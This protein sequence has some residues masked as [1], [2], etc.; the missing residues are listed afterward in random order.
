MGARRWFLHSRR[1]RI[2]A[3]TVTIFVGLGQQAAQAADQVWQQRENEI[4]AAAPTTPGQQSGSAAG[5][6]HRASTSDTRAITDAQG[7]APALAPHQLPME[8]SHLRDSA[9]HLS[10][11]TAS[12]TGTTTSPPSSPAV[13][14]FDPV[15]SVPQPA[16]GDEH[17]EVYHNPDNTDTARISQDRVQF[18]RPDHSWTP[19]D[20][21]LKPTGSGR[22]TK[23]ADSQQIE[24]AG[25]A[26]DPTLSSIAP[27]AA[28][29]VSFGL[30]DAAPAKAQIAG[31]TA[32]YPNVSAG[33]DLQEQATGSGLKENL[34]LHSAAAPVNWVFPFTAKGLSAST[35]P[36][37][38]VVFTDASGAVQVRI[39][40][41][42][43]TD[44]AIDPRSN[45]GASSNGVTYQLVTY[46][47]GPALQVKLDAGW[48]HDPARRFPVMVDP[49]SLTTTAST[50]VGWVNGDS[51]HA[52]SPLLDVGS[53]DNG[54][55]SAEADLRF[56]NFASTFGNDFIRGT[57]LSVYDAWDTSCTPEQVAVTPITVPWDVNTINS[58]QG[59]LQ[60]GLPIGAKSFATSP[61]CLGSAGSAN[62]TTI[63]LNPSTFD[64]WAH[65]AP[66]YGLKLS[67]ETNSDTTWKQLASDHSANA[68]YLSVDFSPYGVNWTGSPT[69]STIPTATTNGVLQV[70][71]QNWGNTAWTPSNGYVLHYSQT[72]SVTGAALASGT[73]PMP[74]TVA[75]QQSTT[76]PIT[77]AKQPAGSPL[78]VTLD[79]WAPGNVAFSS[80]L[81]PTESFTYIGVDMAPQVDGQSPPSNVT[82]GT[83]TP[84]LTASGHDPD[85]YPNPLEFGF[86]V[87]PAAA[88]WPTGC[89]S[90]GWLAAGVTA[91]TVSAGTLAYN[92]SYYWVTEDYD[93]L[94]PSYQSAPSWFTTVVGQPV[95]TSHL[96]QNTDQHGY[97]PEVGNYTTATTDLTVPGAGL[98]LSVQRTYNSLDPRT[99]GAFGAGWWSVL[100]MQAAPDADGTGNVVITY[101]NGQTVRFGLN[102]DGTFTPPQG[103]YATLTPTGTTGYTLVDKDGTTYVFTGTPGAP[104][105]AIASITDRAGH[106]ELFSYTGGHLATVTNT[107]S[108]RTLHI[109]WLT[110]PG[111][112]SAH[113]TSI[114]TDPVTGTDPTTAITATYQYTA[115]ELTGACLPSLQSACTGYGYQAGA[116]DRTAVLDAAPASFW[117]LAEPAGAATATSEVLENEGIDAATSLSATFGA[118]GPNPTATAAAFDGTASF[119]QLPKG[120]VEGTTF[121]SLQLWF[122]TSASGTAQMLFSTDHDAAN[123]ANPGSGAM[124]VLYVGTDNKLHGHF[125]DNTV[126][127]MASANPVNDGKWHQVTIT[128]SAGTQSLYLDGTPIA[129]ET[130]Q[131]LNIDPFDIVGAGVFNAKGWPA[132]PGGNT[133]S[134]FHGSIADV[135]FYPQPLSAIQ[136]SSQYHS[137]VTP[138]A[139]LTKITLPSG[140]PAAGMTYDTHADRVTQ[141]T[142]QNGGA[143]KVGGPTVSGTSAIYRSA[144]LGAAP[145][146]YWRLGDAAGST[147]SSETGSQTGTYTNTTLGATGPFG[148]N[149]SAAATFNGT[150]SSVQLPSSTGPALGGTNPVI[151]DYGP[152]AV[153]L[154]FSTTSSG[155]LFSFSKDPITAAKST[156][157]YDFTP[158]LYVGTDGK[159]YGEFN[160]TSTADDETPMHSSVVVNDGK[161]HHVALSTNGDTQTL[162]LDGMAT[163]SGASWTATSDS[164]YTYVGAGF[165]GNKW[166]ATPQRSGTDNLGSPDYFSGSIAEVALYRH[167]L[168]AADVVHHVKAYGN[169]LSHASPTERIEVQDPSGNPLDYTYD[170][171]N[172]GRLVTAGDAL[173]NVTSYG[174]DTAGFLNTITDPNGVPIITGHDIRGNLISRTTCQSFLAANCATSYYTYFPDDSS[175]TLS[176]DPR[177]DLLTSYRDGR[178]VDS[179]DPT[180]AIR[181][182]YDTNGNLLS[183]VGPSVAGAPSGQMTTTVYT[184]GSATYPSLDGATAPPGLPAHT[185]S[186]SGTTTNYR[187]FANGDIAQV[188]DP[189]GLVT[190][191]THDNLGRLLTAKQTSDSYPAGLV[192]SY[193]YDA[194]GRQSSLTSPGVTD[195][196][197]GTV[198]TAKTTTAYDPDG[199]ITTQTVA[200]T[201][202]SDPARI[203]TTGYDISDRVTSIKEPTGVTTHYGYNLFGNNTSAIDASGT[204]TDYSYD[205]DGRRTT[206]TL[207]GYIGDPVNPSTP[208]DLVTESRA[209]DPAGRLASVTDSMGR[210]TQYKYFDDGSVSAVFQPD[211]A[212]TTGTGYRDAI[213][214]YDLAGN[215]TSKCVDNCTYNPLTALPQNQPLLFQGQYSQYQ[216]DAGDRVTSTQTQYGS[217][218][219][220]NTSLH[221]PLI[222]STNVSYTPDDLPMSVSTSD[223]ASP[224]AGNE[225]TDYTYDPLGRLTSSTAH[226]PLAAQ[227]SA[228][229]LLGQWNLDDGKTLTAHDGSAGAT[230]APSTP[231]AFDGT[232]YTT[233]ST[234]IWNGQVARLVYQT[235]G[236]LVVYRNSDNT[237]LWSSQTGG[238]TSAV[239]VFQTDG[240]L[241]IYSDATFKTAL[242]NSGTSVAGAQGTFNS[243]GD[244]TINSPS[245]AQL[246]STHTAQTGFN[247]PATLSGGVSWAPPLSLDD[248]GSGGPDPASAQ[249]DGTTGQVSTSGPVVDTSKSFTVSLWAMAPD[250]SNGNQTIAAQEGSQQSGFSL[251]FQGPN[252]TFTRSTSDTVNAPTVTSSSAS[253]NTVSDR[254]NHL[255]A[256]YD[257]PS[258][259]MTL[260]IN[261][262]A[263]TSVTD[264]TP[265]NATGPFVIGHGFSNG[266]ASNFFAGKVSDVRAYSRAL[267]PDEIRALANH[268]DGPG[269]RG[270]AG[271]WTLSDGAASTAAVAAGTSTAATIGGI[272]NWTSDH[273]GSAQFNGTSGAI[274][275]HATV[276]L[277]SNYTVAGWVKL[278]STTGS[279]TVLSED[280]SN[281]SGFYLRYDAAASRWAFAAPASDTTGAATASATSTGPPTVGAW[282]YLTGVYDAGAHLLRLYVNGQPAGTAAYTAPAGQTGAIAIGRGE[283]NSA[284]AEFFNGRVSSVQAYQQALSPG[285]IGTLYAGGNLLQQTTTQTTSWTL[286]QRG[287]PTSMTDARGNAPGATK[288]GYTTN[289]SYDEAD[290]LSS[291]LAPP[292]STESGGT[293]AAIT[294]PL[295]LTGYDT[296]GD[297]TE[298]QDADG[299]ITTTGYD[300]DSRPTAVTLA[301]YTAPGSTTP[302]TS[303]TSTT[304]TP[305]GQPKTVT[306]PLNNLTTYAYDQLG[307]LAT[308]T[309]PPINGN[310]TGGIWHS[311]YDT[312]GELASATDPTGAQTQTTY[313]Y[314]GRP[315]TGTQLVRQPAGAA[316]LVDTGI[317]GYDN[318]GNLNSITSPDHVHTTAT[319][320]NVGELTSSTDGA[321]NTTTYGYLNGQLASTTAPDH[322]SRTNAYDLAGHLTGVTDFDATGKPLRTTGISYDAVGNPVSVTDPTNVTTIFDYDATNR[323]TSQLEHAT[324]TTS[325]LTSYGYDAAGRRSRDTDGNNN[326]RITTYNTWGLPEAQIDPSTPTYPSLAERTYTTAYDAA[327]NT[328]TI[329]EPGGVTKTDTH[330][331]LGNLTRETG[332]GADAPT[333]DRV[334]GYDTASRLTSTTEPGGTNTFTYDDRGLV[335][336]TT[337]PSGTS[338][339][340]YNG[341][342]QMA[343]RTDAS[344]TTSYTY[345]TAGRLGTLTDALTS[346]TATYGYNALDQVNHVGYGT[347]NDARTYGYDSLHRLATDTLATSTGTAVSSI[348]YGY[349]LSDRETSK[350]TSG[351]SG[352]SANI[353]TY[354]LAG[355]LA[356]WNNGSATTTYGY[357]LAG[358][359]T[360]AGAGTLTYNARNQLLTDPAN[361]YSYTA[362]GTA[363]TKTV[364]AG[365][366]ERTTSDAF[367]QQITD[368]LTAGTY[369]YDALGR[370]TSRGTTA[371][372]YSGLGNTLASDGTSTYSRDPSG[373]LVATGASG[374]AMLADTDQHGDVVDTHQA[375]AAALAGSTTYDPF[376]KTTAKSGTSGPLGYQ[377]GYTDPTTGH[378]DMGSRWY[379][380]N[381]GQFTGR[382]TASNTPNPVSANANRYAYAND[383][384][385]TGTDPTGHGCWTCW[386]A[387]VAGAIGGAIIGCAV[388]IE[389]GCVEGAAVGG[390]EGGSLAFGWGMA[391]GT[392]SYLAD[393]AATNIADGAWS[394]P[395]ETDNAGTANP[396]SVRTAT[397]NP[398]AGHVGDIPGGRAGTLHHARPWTPPPPPPPP[399][400]TDYANRAEP[401]PT[402][403][404]LGIGSGITTSP[405]QAA[406]VS[407][408][409]SIPAT[410]GSMYDPVDATNT[411]TT[412]ALAAGGTAAGLTATPSGPRLPT[413]PSPMDLFNL[414]NGYNNLRT[415]HDPIGCTLAAIGIV[416]GEALASTL[417][418]ELAGVAETAGAD[419]L[420]IADSVGDASS[421]IDSV[422]DSVRQDINTGEASASG[423]TGA[424]EP[425][426]LARL[427]LHPPEKEGEAGHASIEVVQF[428]GDTLHTHQLGT[429]GTKAFSRTWTGGPGMDGIISILLPKSSGALAAQEVYQ[430]RGLLGMYDL[431][432]K[433]CITYCGD[434]LRAG[435]VEGV[436]DT[437]GG[438]LSWLF[439]TDFK[440]E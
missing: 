136:I 329:T 51:N 156:Y 158:A 121:L 208:R 318:E 369:S 3:V 100:D 425:D 146:G 407:T 145:Y 316:T 154:W 312:N 179:V 213:F 43:M 274:Q 258:G 7:H 263:T 228:A 283:E 38:D 236:N 430:N 24:L 26:T 150:S 281:V 321:G 241:V 30:A 297:A 406:A 287:L 69:W 373:G 418:T 109:T 426:G 230:A 252:W 338:S 245:G 313:D 176:P 345:D 421:S 90:S 354:D 394:W 95:I 131:L 34:V 23:T 396:P 296:F 104:T 431:D 25:Q 120:Q 203:T 365:G 280:R 219:V 198:H 343:G 314:L 265:F 246:F 172:G 31:D 429:I 59:Y 327:A 295:T 231:L 336:S 237:A 12:V 96:A 191:Y 395:W 111:A 301:S 342:G 67:A 275:T 18:Q 382:D 162:Y 58:R 403:P 291:T 98:P 244:L 364:T 164:D 256:A 42:S 328:A 99:A 205:P 232:T 404:V 344:G 346:A 389:I 60:D 273:G 375:A 122:T 183:T 196:V 212:S 115:D 270:L 438:I 94:E 339:F 405:L 28:H 306:D 234:K 55:D 62:W 401:H 374:T 107:T 420:P 341:D 242:W 277:A 112:T 380:P 315:A 177:N 21:T 251:G 286:D 66:N 413:P 347:G 71:V 52:G 217:T 19:I 285:Q 61:H 116:H 356:T 190:S 210:V 106:A 257:Q 10:T 70:P 89:T 351:F 308:R 188:T 73:A 56:D 140:K 294:R 393:Q 20:N 384:P 423:G 435:G 262:V 377:S 68:P 2:T 153:E 215:L 182:T 155:V 108:K 75:P 305:L 260:Y 195:H 428:G 376:G 175:T 390:E 282:T 276:N 86:W 170:P 391:A 223:N 206:S 385:L 303:T 409:L 49:T 225:A 204:E 92:Q 88:T 392:A 361:S 103:R 254:W 358:N 432:T 284:A 118:T 13:S 78:R 288:A 207:H 130:G 298:T 335:T 325:I 221:A 278:N 331:A 209:Y 39:P 57:W 81:A 349:D 1:V 79:M 355:R 269:Q 65:S 159:L 113:V 253:T 300:S 311:T 397:G 137:A 32:M 180:Y 439:E 148:R 17:T 40:H 238:H 74:G 310:P 80:W 202:G 192:T 123:T 290:Q 378:V 110:P 194:A 4:A 387:G 124:P 128:G 437:T 166:P 239:L 14:S 37:G 272:V 54:I 11:P 427:H 157:D 372:T 216:V 411:L 249:F 322:S 330:D 46:H 178:S 91:W 105:F 117:R 359:R 186:P 119:V 114:V 383:N 224:S 16:L 22:W 218:P 53:Y 48:L 337:G 334:L 102:H 271:S 45:Q 289:Y 139:L 33:V 320:D 229:L 135:A 227:A 169:S 222:R 433:S 400:P 357:D 388:T 434:V 141:I 422:S 371:F 419:G 64:Q 233:S 85:N 348:G 44:S 408:P 360:S 184:D 235:D 181:Y 268:D 386:V 101:P 152:A 352:A 264:T 201:T 138:A 200:D 97:D 211:P 324:P 77:I 440:L 187:Y 133:W 127:G 368:S 63:G 370:L 304:Y 247:N 333:I 82:E 15:R 142:D 293:A 143:W 168:S 161:W 174:Y 5:R 151:P 171:Y 381:D 292:V 149:D 302:I 248:T 323:L 353:Y 160:D 6:S 399:S 220:P 93:G 279:Q 35:T 125:W 414:A 132:A 126:A 87:C 417:G 436:P 27:D 226:D 366:T 147:A 199:D 367:D 173:N 267:A 240:N 261:G 167:E 398:P 83:L 362:R 319:Y 197:T 412:G 47:G 185:T 363:A 326:S 309:D 266:A 214:R 402:A 84:T 29:Q 36:G 189:A 9:T 317:Y 415:C 50:Y 307:D 259:K 72:N 163:S 134:H 193:A 410:A 41:G 144:V 350:T 255:V 129:S 243:D 379:D 340:G 250:L 332:S 424:T 416:P 76:V 165:T 8:S 299:N